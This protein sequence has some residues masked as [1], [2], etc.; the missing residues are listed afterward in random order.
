MALTAREAEVQ[1]LSFNLE[2]EKYRQSVGE[3]KINSSFRA[4]YDEQ[5]SP[6]AKMSQS[7][8]EVFN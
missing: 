7:L 5:L 2:E 1:D 8:D 6:T 3:K 4:V